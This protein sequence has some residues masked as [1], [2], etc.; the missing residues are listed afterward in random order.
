MVTDSGQT[1]VR[2]QLDHPYKEGSSFFILCM[3]G[4]HPTLVAGLFAPSNLLALNC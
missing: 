1:V 3:L 2:E 4:F